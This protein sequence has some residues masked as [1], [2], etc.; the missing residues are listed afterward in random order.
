MVSQDTIG[1]IHQKVETC[2][3][4]TRNVKGIRSMA[5]DNQIALPSVFEL[6]LKSS[7]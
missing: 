6:V 7:S 2:N 5:I 3:I 1:I 4:T